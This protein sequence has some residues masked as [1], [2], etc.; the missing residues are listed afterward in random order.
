MTSQ[1]FQSKFKKGVNLLHQFDKCLYYNIECDCGDKS[2]GTT[3]TVECDTELGLIELHF[4]KDVQFD[5]WMYPEPGI[6]NYFKRLAYRWKKIIKLIFTGE[7]S[8]ESDFVLIDIEH[9]NNFLE[10]MQEGRDYCIKCQQERDKPK[11]N[12]QYECG[13]SMTNCS[14]YLSDG[15]CGLGNNNSPVSINQKCPNLKELNKKMLEL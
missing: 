14:Y 15:R 6:V 1:E 5:Y 3:M 12:S 4:Y 13:A 10:A 9:I 7:I 8:L 2:C 11:S